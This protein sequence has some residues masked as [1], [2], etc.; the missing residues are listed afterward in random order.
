MFGLIWR[1][2]RG[3]ARQTRL[4]TPKIVSAR[5]GGRPVQAAYI[6]GYA[7]GINAYIEQVRDG[8]LPPPPELAGDA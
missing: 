6:D 5:N 7:A 2:L 4:M 3:S 8:T 1:M